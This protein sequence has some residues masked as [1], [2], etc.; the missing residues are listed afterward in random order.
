MQRR[1]V[2]AGIPTALSSTISAGAKVC[3][4]CLNAHEKR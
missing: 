1:D 3:A 2:S 4:G